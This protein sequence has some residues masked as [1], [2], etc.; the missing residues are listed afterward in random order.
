M[1]NEVKKVFRSRISIL[2]TGFLLAILILISIPI[3]HF[4]IFQGMYFLGGVFILFV[5]LLSGMRYVISGDKLYTKIWFIPC[6]NEKISNIISVEQSYILIAACAASLKKLRIGLRKGA[7]SPFTLISP[8]REQEFIEELKTINP[9]IH[10][11][12]SHKKRKWCIW[13]WDI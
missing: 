7:Y 12:V 10:I 11:N 5:F 3:F 9:N 13:D 4:K 1:G 6:E 2:L 8:V